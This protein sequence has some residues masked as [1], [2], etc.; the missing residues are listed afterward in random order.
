MG[1]LLCLSDAKFGWGSYLRTS[2]IYDL[3]V[4]TVTA[5]LRSFRHTSESGSLPI[6]AVPY[7]PSCS[8]LQSQTFEL[9][10]ISIIINRVTVLSLHVDLF[11]CQWTCTYNSIDFGVA[12]PLEFRPQISFCR[13]NICPLKSDLLLPFVVRLIHSSMRWCSRP[14]DKIPV[15]G[16]CI[17]LM[18]LFGPLM[19]LD[20][21]PCICPHPGDKY[22]S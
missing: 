12:S 4:S 3:P 19:H 18:H 5:F 22:R 7:P 11:D 9:M 6:V 15:R 14:S 1:S 13:G 10:R 21:T 16:H 20:I 2:P 8:S 17:T